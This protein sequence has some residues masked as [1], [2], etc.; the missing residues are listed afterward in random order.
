[1]KRK[2]GS[3][4]PAE[5][6]SSIFTAANGKKQTSMIVRDISQFKKTQNQLKISIE[7]YKQL[8][9]NNPLPNII[10]DVENFEI[11]DANEAAVKYYNY[12]YEKF[13]KSTILDFLPQGGDI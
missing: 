10:Y 7:S 1:M 3:E 2:D 13:K 4:F 12:T 6:T 5:I 8:F 9:K 11:V